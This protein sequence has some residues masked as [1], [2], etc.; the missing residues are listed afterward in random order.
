[1][2]KINV[3]VEWI[4]DIKQW[5]IEQL[6]EIHIQEIPPSVYNCE[7]FKKLFVGADKSKPRKCTITVSDWEDI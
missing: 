6:D 7:V 2:E 5:H 4:P 1:M 3:R